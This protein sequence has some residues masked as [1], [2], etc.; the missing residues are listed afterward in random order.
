MLGSYDKEYLHTTKALQIDSTFV[1]TFPNMTIEDWGFGLEFKSKPAEKIRN[2]KSIFNWRQLMNG[3]KQSC[4]MH[5][6]TST[7]NEVGFHYCK[8]CNDLEFEYTTD[9]T[10]RMVQSN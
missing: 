5:D 1:Q 9:Y 10:I 6:S 2:I 4:L 8:F 7:T 3:D